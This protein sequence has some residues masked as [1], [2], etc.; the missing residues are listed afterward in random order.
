MRT[1]ASP[2]AASPSFSPAWAAAVR[3]LIRWLDRS[4][5]ADALLESLPRT[6]TAAER[7]RVQHLF[8]G[9]LRHLSRLEREV[10]RRI[11]RAPRVRVKAV[12]LTAGFEL[13]E[14]G[15]EGHVARV[16]HHAVEQA[17]R[18]TS[19]SEARLVNAVVRRM[20]DGLAEPLPTDASPASLAQRFSHPEWMVAR[21]LT[22]FG[23]A[24]T[25][26]LL[27]LHQTPA[28][29]H[30]RWRGEPGAVPEWLRAGSAPSFF[31]IPAGRWPDVLALRQ[32]GQLYIQDPAT[33]HAVELLQPQLGETL[34]DA[35]AAPGGKSVFIADRLRGKGRIVALDLPGPR[36]DRLRENLAAVCG[37][38]VDI[39]GIDLETA[40]PET[41]REQGL[42]ERFDGVLVDVPC[43]NTGVMRH[44][45]DVRWRL[46]PGDIG[47]HADQQ[48][49]LLRAAAARVSPGGRLV[50]STCSLEPEEN[51][52][53]VAD[54]L[55]SPAGRGWT[56]EEQVL[57][58]PFET[59][60]DGAG[61]FCLRA[62]R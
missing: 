43:S 49:S 53:V 47:R 29:I 31:D 40:R 55:G 44:R 1:S 10:S 35:C 45:V 34:L 11:P 20:A 33:R 46:Q 12:L 58:R 3:L 54:F 48:R 28:R 4:E 36:L 2:A 38:S 50:Y 24:A 15:E 41:F 62:P 56:L 57:A 37:V 32:A 26:R 21:W 9:V 39:A 18:L 13:I 42:P 19:A 61:A 25:E 17:K 59:G 30:V 23:P 60:E 52:G 16:V 6:L 14:G 51:E 27:E 22:A 8:L 7:A 5:R